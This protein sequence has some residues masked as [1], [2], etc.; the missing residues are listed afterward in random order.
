MGNHHTANISLPYP[1]PVVLDACAQVL[2]NTG[3]KVNTVD[4]T[5]GM[6]FAVR[7]MSLWSYGENVTVQVG[8]VAADAP[9]ELQIRS[10]LAFG[11]VDWG[12][13]RKNVEKVLGTLTAFLEQH[14]ADSR[15]P[16]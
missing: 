2:A 10:A 5:R 1:F 6:I 13:N 14:A 7:G 11:L 12:R 16:G 15:L 8:Q 9:C 3:F 4:P